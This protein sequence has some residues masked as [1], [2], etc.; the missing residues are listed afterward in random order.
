MTNAVVC[1]RGG[2][3]G[4]DDDRHHEHGG[5]QGADGEE[6]GCGET[7]FAETDGGGARHG[8]HHGGAVPWRAWRARVTAW[9]TAWAG[10]VARTTAWSAT[11]ARPSSQVSRPMTGIPAFRANAISDNV[12]YSPPTATTASA[13]RTTN[14]LR[15]SP[16]PVGM[17]MSTCGLASARWRPGR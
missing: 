17:A 7:D 4:Y 1:G 15:A 14:A 2:S 16:R 9:A 8:S 3:T 10:S 6:T 11:P 13:A 12:P 5:Q